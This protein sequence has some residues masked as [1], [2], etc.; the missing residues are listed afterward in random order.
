MVPSEPVVG[1]AFSSKC[2]GTAP[3]D[4]Q[5]STVFASWVDESN[6]ILFT[7]SSTDEVCLALVI[8]PFTPASVGVYR[9]MVRICFVFI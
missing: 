4:L 1:E 3:P 9:C 8:D 6:S 2:T 7:N 5:G